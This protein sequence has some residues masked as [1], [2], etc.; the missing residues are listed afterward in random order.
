MAVVP[1]IYLNIA[2][3]AAITSSPETISTISSP[4]LQ[5]TMP[6]ILV[7]LKEKPVA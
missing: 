1:T 7:A 4:T 2:R 6:L 3:V 5:G